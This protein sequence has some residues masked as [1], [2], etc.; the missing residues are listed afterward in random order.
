ME[1]RLLYLIMVVA[2]GWAVTFTLRALPFLIFA[3]RDRRLPYWVL[4]FGNFV[5]PVIIGGLIVYSYSGLE[6]RT[7][8]PY[9]AGALT[10][11]LQL[12][13]RNPLVSI[14]GGTVV[15]M[16]LLSF[17]AGC[18]TDADSD[19]EIGASRPCVEITKLG[20]CKFAGKFVEPSDVGEMLQKHG[21]PKSTTIHVLVEDGYDNKRAL[22][23]FQHNVLARAGYSRSIVVSKRKFEAT[24]DYARNPEEE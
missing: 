8:W 14:L 23:V 1:N 18:V 21:V 6:W 3:G 10:V 20:G 4:K 2:A 24:S 15:Y 19:F 17:C 12:W 22:W 5:S 13:K 16:L 7:A 11:G 9:L